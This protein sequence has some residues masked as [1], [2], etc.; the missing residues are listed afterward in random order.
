MPFLDWIPLHIRRL[1]KKSLS[2]ELNSDIK[3]NYPPLTPRAQPNKKT[4]TFDDI[5]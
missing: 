3:D 1:F 4:F 2:I 5:C